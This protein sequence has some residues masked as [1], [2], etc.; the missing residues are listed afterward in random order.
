MLFWFAAGAITVQHSD[1]GLLG[2]T[3]STKFLHLLPP[4]AS[5]W[6]RP[7]PYNVCRGA[8]QVVQGAAYLQAFM[9][10]LALFKSRGGLQLEGAQHS[11]GDLQISLARAVQVRVVLRLAA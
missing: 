6:L 3:S 1:G 4:N 10:R 11:V 9:D 2:T 7:L 5:R 8:R